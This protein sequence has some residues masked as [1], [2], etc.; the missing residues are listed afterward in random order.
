MPQ[1]PFLSTDPDAGQQVGPPRSSGFLS[2]DPNIGEAVPDFRMEVTAHDG[3]ADSAADF[4]RGWLNRV[5]PLPAL[6]AFSELRD[7]EWSQAMA[8]A[9]KGDYS[10][11][12]LRAIKAQPASVAGNMLKGIGKSH[13]DQLV[14]AYRA[15]K[16]GRVSEAIGHATAAIVPILGPVA[17]DTAGRWGSGKI[18]AAEA[19]GE[20]AGLL[21]PFGLKYGKEALQTGSLVPTAAK[22]SAAPPLTAR[23]PSIVQNQS[24]A[25]RAAV[26]F[27]VDHGVPIDMATATGN[28]FVRGAQAIS[29]HTTPVGASIAERAKHSQ[30]TNLTRVGEEL[31]GRANARIQPGSAH[32]TPGSPVTPEQAGTGVR[33][34]V[35]RAVDKLH[36]ESNTAYDAFRR[37]AND[38]AHAKTVPS[39]QTGRVAG[40]DAIKFSVDERMAMPVDLRA[41]KAA[42]KPIYD[43][44]VARWPIAR[45]HASP[46]L[47]ALENLANDADYA[48]AVRVEANLSAAKQLAR[49]HGGA[50]KLAV[51]QLEQAVELAVG[52]ASPQAMQALRT[53][54]AATKAKYEALGI[55]E[56]LSAEPVQVFRQATYAKDAGIDL[57]RRVETQSGPS[58][59]RD[60]GRAW[61]E[62]A[63]SQATQEGSFSHTARLWADWNK[64]GPQTK[65]LLFR[66]KALVTDLTNFFL[67]AKKIGENPNPSGS[68]L[69]GSINAMGVMLLHPATGVPYVIG[70]SSLAAL[71]HS[72]TFVQAM[73]RGMR[74]PI[75]NQ[76]AKTAAASEIFSIAGDAVVPLA[77]VAERQPM[78]PATTDQHSESTAR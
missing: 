76:A 16:E 33:T 78:T 62:D 36:T 47:K 49:D 32:I 71:L 19:V 60:V 64:L 74:V 4:G 44:L 3:I 2:T 43:D 77:T 29:E 11:A 51:R 55:L 9:D 34:S 23:L 40:G 28:R 22:V 61:L 8:A 54:R 52:R 31:A 24:P 65:Q 66:N 15:G 68:A 72:Q 69:V 56:R 59:L 48:P 18:G 35:Q 50:A 63:L 13:W 6:K 7:S 21:T 30:A 39:T 27:G 41:A 25:E 14:R 46:G 45:Q 53:G 73:V 12:L 17:A 20:T 38:P 5:N 58:A 70:A 10:G 67:L 1:S 57:L 26:Q 75:G 37:L 42:L